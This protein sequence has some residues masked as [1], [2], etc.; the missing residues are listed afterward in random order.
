MDPLVRNNVVV[1]G[2]PEGRTIMFAHGFGGNQDSW[3]FVVPEFEADYRI[4]L[5]DF[6]GTGGSDR[7]AYDRARYDSLYGYA[8]DVVEILDRLGLDEVAFVGHSVS[9]MIGVLASIQRPDLFDR[10][11]LIGPSA[12]YLDTEGYHGG[13]SREAIDELLM[14]LEAN[15]TGFSEH[16][17]PLLMGYPERPELSLAL[18][19]VIGRADPDIA[20]HFAR[21]T[22]LSDN[23]RDLADVTVPT[24]I[25]QSSEDNIA[26]PPVGR[27]VHEQIPKSRFVMMEARGHVPHLSDPAELSAHLA[28]YLA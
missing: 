2:N 4:V 23:R 12:R 14:S 8:D 27:Y 20:A 11:V 22:F 18:A 26:S 3:R 19:E 9:G 15:F 17:A 25:L 10:L 21:V 24:L 7:S 6:V 28:A 16:L 13:F 1:T 5:F